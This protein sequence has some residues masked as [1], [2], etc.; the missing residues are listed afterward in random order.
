[1][2]T[3]TDNTTLG[4]I[5]CGATYSGE[6]QHCVAVVP[7]STHPDGMAH[8]TAKSSTIDLMWAKGRGTLVEPSSIGLVRDDRGVWRRPI[9]EEARARLNASRAELFGS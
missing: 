7:W 8:I 3:C 9:S 1:M 5:G 2:A 4:R 6:M